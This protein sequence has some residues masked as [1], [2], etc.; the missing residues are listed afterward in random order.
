MLVTLEGTFLG[1][2][3]NEGTPGWELSAVIVGSDAKQYRDSD[4][5]AVP[6]NPLVDAPTLEA[7]GE[8]EGNFV[9]ELP[10]EA[11][12]GAALFVEETLSFDEERAYFTLS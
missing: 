3:N 1:Q 5:F 4:T 7:G 11:L 8:F 12:D 6:P 2:E 10:A 9:I